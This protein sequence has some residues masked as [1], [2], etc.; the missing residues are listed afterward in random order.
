MRDDPEFIHSFVG[1]RGQ[2]CY[3]SDRLL[4]WEEC[5]PQILIV[6]A[7]PVGLTAAA[8]LARYGVRVRIIDRSPLPTE[9][10]KALVVWSRTL[11]L[12]DRMGC[13]Q[14]FLE[15]GLRARGASMRSGATVLGHTRLDAIASDYNF[16]LMIPQRDT[17]RLMAEHLHA[18]GI[19]VERQVELMSFAEAA[20]GVKAQLSHVDGRQETV[21][22]PWLIGCDG[23]HS[24]VRHG[25]GVE[26]QGS[27]QGDDWLLADVRL[28]GTDAPVGDEIAT[29]LHHD[30]PFV[31]FPIP[32]GRARII[33]TIGKTDPAHPRPDPTLADV[34]TMV[35]KRAGGG[36]RAVEPV[37]LTNFRINERKV[38]DYR[39]G[40]IFLAGDAAH[41]HSPAGGQG[42]NTGMQDVINLA[43]KLALV[44]HGQAASTLLDSYSPERTAVGDM[45]LRNAGRLTDLATLA[46]PAAQTARNFALRILLGFHAVQDK[47]AT[48][49]SEIEI[50]YT[51]SPLSSGPSGGA[52][53]APE[54]YHGAPPGSGSEPRFVLYTADLKKG[55]TLT[56][57]FPSLLEAKPRMSHEPQKLL[58]V[59]PDDYVGFSSDQATWGEAE[60]YLQRLAPAH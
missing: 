19:K 40:R 57:R 41:I 44:T 51:G 23:A 43:W 54:R 12:M 29:Y 2:L 32:G 56:A 60:R 42:M 9:T 13:T 17:E 10:S 4:G 20:D 47:M 26:F 24:T 3:W 38:S 33:G 1:N 58:I 48:T 22:T 45:V 55:A 46:N 14:D 31:V 53:W 34:Q 7:G 15:T 27:T 5:M 30:G 35:D 8:E 28:E 18:F 52:R 11:E 39:R 21:E 36:F 25:I 59:R 6:G 49:M 16:A 37:W 50:A